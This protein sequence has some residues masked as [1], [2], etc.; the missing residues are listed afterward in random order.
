MDDPDTECKDTKHDVGCKRADNILARSHQDSMLPAPKVTY[1]ESDGQ[2]VT[3]RSIVWYHSENQTLT[4]IR[5]PCIQIKSTHSENGEEIWKPL[6]YV[7]DV[8]ICS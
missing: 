3:K 2:P 5:M 8:G 4:T 6:Q 1:I 7:H